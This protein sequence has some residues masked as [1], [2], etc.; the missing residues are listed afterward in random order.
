MTVT[1]DE[2]ADLHNG[3]SVN[4]YFNAGSMKQSDFRDFSGGGSSGSGERRSS[5]SGG[6]RPDFS[7]GMPSGFDPSNMPDFGRRKDE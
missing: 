3:E 6:E 2:D 5:S 1:A 7:G 4:V